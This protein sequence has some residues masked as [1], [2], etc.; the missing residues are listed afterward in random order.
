[1]GGIIIFLLLLPASLKSSI[2]VSDFHFVTNQWNQNS[3]IAHS[4]RHINKDQNEHDD[5]CIVKHSTVAWIVHNENEFLLRPHAIIFISPWYHFIQ[6]SKTTH[7]TFLFCTD[8]HISVNCNTRH[9]RVQL[10]H[11]FHVH[12]QMITVSKQVQKLHN[13][14][15]W[16]KI[17]I[18]ISTMHSNISHGY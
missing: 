16:N 3:S 5:N 14:C 4:T 12:Q 17:F 10:M 11:T 18:L 6:Y 7:N 15:W 1:M 8:S 2:A 13:N 9:S